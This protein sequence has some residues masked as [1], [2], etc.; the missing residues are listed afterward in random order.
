MELAALAGLRLTHRRGGEQRMRRT[1]LVAVDHEHSRVDRAIERVRLGQ[2]RQLPDPERRAERHREQDVAHGV[3]QPGHARAQQLLDVVRNRQVLADRRHAVVQ[4]LAPELQHEQRVAQ[5]RVVEPAE[6][7]ARQ[8]QPE[9]LR[10][11]AARSRR[12]SEVAPRR[13]PAASL[14]ARA[15]G[16][17]GDP[18]VGRAGAPRAR[19]RGGGRRRRAR[20]P[21]PGRATGRRRRPRA[22]A[23]AGPASAGRRAAR[24]RSRAAPEARRSAARGGAR[25]RAHAV[26]AAARRRAPRPPRRRAGRSA[27][28]TRAACRR[29]SRARRARAG[30]GCDRPR[31]RRPRESSCRSPARR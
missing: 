25:P 23:G 13:A 4:H 26:A 31:R 7:V 17:T 16:P 2:R 1:D 11:D 30:R 24:G 28:R 27:P 15:R 6:H 18:G 21:R 20:P 3:R 22:A 9:P 10:E 12:G 5:R 14:R 29:R 8:G 19:R